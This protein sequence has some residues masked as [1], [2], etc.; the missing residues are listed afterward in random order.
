MTFKGH[1]LEKWWP[2]SFFVWLMGFLK[3]KAGPEE[4]FSHL[5]CLHR[6]V[7]DCV[8]DLQHCQ[9]LCLEVQV[10]NGTLVY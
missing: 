10:M 7:K 2:Y 1:H 3:K 8:T 4:H 6:K 9:K 5:C